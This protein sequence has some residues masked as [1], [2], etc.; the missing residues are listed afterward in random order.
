MTPEQIAATFQVSRAVIF[1]QLTRLLGIATNA[2]TEN[3]AD[4]E[5]PIAASPK[6]PA[7]DA[8]QQAAVTSPTPALIVA[9]PGTG[10]TSTL[11]AR[12]RWL[13][14]EGAQ[15]DHILCLT[16][17]RKAA[18][19]MQDRITAAIDA[20]DGMPT[21][22]TFHRFGAD[23]LRT[24]GFHLGLRPDFRLVDRIGAF[25][26][27]RD[28]APELPLNHFVAL[29]NPTQHFNDLLDAISQAKDELVTPER[30]QEL[31]EH[32]RVL[33]ADRRGDIGEIRQERD[34]LHDEIAVI[35]VTA[36]SQFL[37][38]AGVDSAN[39]ERAFGLKDRFRLMH[40]GAHA[41]G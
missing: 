32:M 2:A 38:I 25:F 20:D 24:Y 31:A 8:A 21:V 16:F 26:L 17:S 23:L 18:R 40:A 29:G 13:V 36:P 10:K 37:L 9:G 27:L 33:L 28:I 35:G 4:T 34:C 19:E 22:T 39:L 3:I 14:A 30:Y 12:V 6:T 1:T 7:L 15:T 5:E 41:L 11:V